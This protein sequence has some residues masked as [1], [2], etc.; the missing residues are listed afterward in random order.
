MDTKIIPTARYHQRRQRLANQLRANGGGVAILMTSAEIPRNRDSD[1]PYRWDSYFYYLTGF[2]EPESAVIIY[3]TETGFR[4]ALFCREKNEEREIWDG[5]RY[6]P[7]AAKEL[8]AVD[9]TFPIAEFDTVLPRLMTNQNTL[10]YALGEGSLVEQH[11]N[12]ALTKVRAQSRSGIVAPKTMIDVRAVLDEMR[13]VKDA[14]EV[15]IMR[16]AA[17]ISAQAHTV[18]MQRC[19]PGMFEY[20]VEAE[21]LYIFKKHGS[22]FPAYGSIVAG[23]ANACV[24]HYRENDARLRNGDILLI[25]A[26]C[27]LDGYASDITRSFPVN[28]RFSKGQRKLYDLVLESQ[29]AAIAATKPGAIFNAPHEAATKVLVQGMIDLGL[30]KGT[31]EESLESGSYKRFYMHRTSHWI[32][33]DVHDCGDYIEPGSPA[34]HLP[35]DESAPLKPAIPNRVLHPGMVLTI[36]PGIYVR[37]AADIP[38]EY[39]DIGIRIED[40]ALVTAQGCDILTKD[41]VKTANDIEALMNNR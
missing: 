36:E 3:T 29:F 35:T 4:T 40:D 41:I 20:E 31:V 25:D 7:K 33:M 16:R 37:A 10:S 15:D 17:V 19:K 39:H 27:E 8:F 9:E 18:A 22:Q 32:G 23:G 28:G 6:G 14:E 24:L 21:L 12:A 2:I 34:A 26:G 11:V 5:Y 30:L 13:L 1:F 38:E